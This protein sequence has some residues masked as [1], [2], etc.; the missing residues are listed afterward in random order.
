VIV[1]CFCGRRVARV[2]R[3]G[4]RQLAV[5]DVDVIAGPDTWGAWRKVSGG[6]RRQP[7]APITASDA[8]VLLELDGS[9]PVYCPRHRKIVVTGAEF[10][11]SLRHG[12]KVHPIQQQST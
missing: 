9:M 7:S 11:L 2:E 5:Y 6:S 12:R 3:L 8:P 1:R 10:D 4:P